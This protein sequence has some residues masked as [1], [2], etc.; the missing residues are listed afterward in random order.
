MGSFDANFLTTNY[1]ELQLDLVIKNYQ[2]LP[3]TKKFFNRKIKLQFELG[4]LL[5]SVLVKRNF[6]GSIW[7]VQGKIG[8][9]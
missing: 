2:I 4:V 1:L 9:A 8:L 7:D 6:F 3:W 5:N